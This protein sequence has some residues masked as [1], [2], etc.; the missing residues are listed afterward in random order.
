MKTVNVREVPLSEIINLPVHPVADV[1]PMLD[2]VTKNRDAGDSKT[3]TMP[4]LASS[5]EEFG[6]QEPIV[7]FR[8][9]D[10]LM[11]L[12]GRNRRHACALAAKNLK[13]SQ[14][15]FMV[16]V[17]DFEGTDQEAEDYIFTLNLDRRDLT[18]GQRAEAAVKYWSLYDGRHG[19]DRKSDQAD[20]FVGLKGETREILARKFRVGVTAVQD[21]RNQY[22]AIEERET[23]AKLAAEEAAK[24]R[25]IAE[26]KREELKAAAVAQEKEK[27]AVLSR[28]ANEATLKAAEER[29]NAEQYQQEANKKRSAMERV[30][31]GKA[32]LNSIKTEEKRDGKDPREV[33]IEKRSSSFN[34]AFKKL[35]DDGS[36][37]L[38]NGRPNDQENVR[39][40]F[41]RICEEFGGIESFEGVTSSAES[42]QYW[43]AVE[44][45]ARE[46]GERKSN[47]QTVNV[48]HTKPCGCDFSEMEYCDEC[49]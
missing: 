1:F 25:Q 33:E 38:E 35:V 22:K 46:A 31:S 3:I 27:A 4:E 49:Q 6:L 8:G 19:G 48:A 42:A 39:L 23:L 34:Q 29:E 13:V 14:D 5:I 37:L 24:Q 9:D 30:R 16:K 17:E 45:E 20:E 28:E 21:V 43:D 36:W 40:K 44:A 18:T 32:T 26:Q 11:L 7:L 12:D 2:K 47:S 10:G 15:E 41:I